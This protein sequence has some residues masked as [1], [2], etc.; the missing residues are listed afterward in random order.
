MGKRY[1]HDSAEMRSYRHTTRLFSE[2]CSP[3]SG[4][5][6]D[7][8]PWLRFAPNESFRKLKEARMLLDAW[9]DKELQQVEAGGFHTFAKLRTC[10]VYDVYVY[11]AS[12]HYM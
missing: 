5:E 11:V 4:M 10:R 2:A 3:V 9:M 8:F 1:D 6:L 12:F 7:L